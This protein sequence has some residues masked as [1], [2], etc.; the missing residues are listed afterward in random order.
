[1][2]IQST[3][4]SKSEKKRRTKPA[5]EPTEGIPASVLEQ[6]PDVARDKRKKRD[7]TETKEQN[8]LPR[9]RG[10]PQAATS[11]ENFTLPDGVVRLVFKAE[12]LERLGISFPTL[13]KWMRANEFPR[14]RICGGKSGGGKS[15]WLSNEVDE[16]IAALPV[17]RLKGDAPD[18]PEQQVGDAEA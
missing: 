2:S 13:W 11:L 4:L 8:K 5:A 12:L 16:W 9:S 14:A 15:C 3:G 18:S 7:A 17:R 1:M 10:P 6:N